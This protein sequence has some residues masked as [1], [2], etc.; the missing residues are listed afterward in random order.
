MKMWYI[1][2]YAM[3]H[4]A[5]ARHTENMQFSATKM[6]LKGNKLSKVSQKKRDIQ[7]HLIYLWYI[8]CYIQKCNALNEDAQITFDIRAQGKKDRENKKSRQEGR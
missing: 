6:E 5:T 7:D 2:I 4:N 8:I 1:Y 3:G